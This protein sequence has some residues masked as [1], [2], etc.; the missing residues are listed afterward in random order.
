M[1][2]RQFVS[3]HRLAEIFHH[4]FNIPI[5]EGSLVRIINRGRKHFTNI[6]PMGSPFL[7]LYTIAGGVTLRLPQLPI[8]FVWSI[9]CANSIM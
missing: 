8:K 5:G 4:V 9:Y 6:F 2:F 1:K 3:F 7:S